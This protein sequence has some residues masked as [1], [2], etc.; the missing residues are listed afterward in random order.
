MSEAL[1][2]LR[3]AEEFGFT[4]E[5]IV[6]GSVLTGGLV[7]SPE[8]MT[9]LTDVT[10]G[11]IGAEDG[12]PTT[13]GPTFILGSDTWVTAPSWVPNTA[14]NTNQLV[15]TDN[16][17]LTVVTGDG[18]EVPTKFVRP[19]ACHD[20]LLSNGNPVTEYVAIHGLRARF[21]LVSSGRID[22]LGGGCALDC[23]MCPLASSKSGYGGI[24]P[25]E[26][27]LEAAEAVKKEE[28]HPPHHVLI[29]GGSP[30]KPDFGKFH[31][32]CVAL[33]EL[34]SDRP[35][36]L[37]AV[38]IPGSLDFPALKKAGLRAVSLN[39]EAHVDTDF[40]RRALRAKTVYQKQGRYA[41]AITAA[42]EAGLEAR[43]L[44][45]IPGEMSDEDKGLTT[46]LIES[47]I[48]LGATPI[49]SPLQ[50]DKDAP[51]PDLHEPT[52]IDIL[53]VASATKELVE[54]IGHPAVTSAIQCSACAHNVFPSPDQPIY[55][56]PSAVSEDNVVRSPLSTLPDRYR[57][58][59]L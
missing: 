46:E 19:A 41:E 2:T 23:Q 56:V 17:R 15:V 18:Y 58:Q 13:E 27:I 20:E 10:G 44:V 50:H 38:P 31:D 39:T 26:A 34:F 25:L 6:K 57:P 7:I 28:V 4:P 59:M 16:V 54:S 42:I 14:T 32:T 29:S 48:E 43:S 55:R 5:N 1:N 8:A 3:L 22:G 9:L 47:I 24:K 21:S 51:I 49:L 12:Y 40:A 37:M 33:I 11:K 36:D 30:R 35:V 45:L 53:R 52:L